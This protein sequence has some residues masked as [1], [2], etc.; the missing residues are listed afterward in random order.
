MGVYI[1]NLVLVVN[2]SHSINLVFWPASENHSLL[3]VVSFCS[4][5]N[6]MTGQRISIPKEVIVIRRPGLRGARF[7][8]EKTEQR[9]R[10]ENDERNARESNRSFRRNN[11]ASSELDIDIRKAESVI[12]LRSS[13]L[14]ELAIYENSSSESL[15]GMKADSIERMK[16]TLEKTKSEIAEALKTLV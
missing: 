3:S 15:T 14:R 11:L 12:N 10:E 13:L 6:V 1:L 5:N 8:T 4:A 7:T 2:Y 9:I 16:N